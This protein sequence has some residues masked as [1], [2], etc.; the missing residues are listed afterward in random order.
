MI[1]R[2]R[3]TLRSLPLFILA[4]LTLAHGLETKP[5]HVG[6]EIREETLPLQL[7]QRVYEVMGLKEST[8][9][10][11]K[12]SYPASIPSS[13]SIRLERNAS[14]ISL[15]KS[16]RLLN[17]EKLIFKAESSDPAY[18]LVTVEAEGV[19]AQPHVRER[20]LVLFNIV[21][22]ELMLGIPHDAWWVGIAAFLCLIIALMIPRFLPLDQ[23]LKYDSSQ[24]AD[25]AKVS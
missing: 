15:G 14:G 1:R 20:D 25:I 8:W 3:R 21:C 24:E 10:E 4:S 6:K 22:D 16:R 18:V 9:Y 12:I 13:F 19:V 2:S 11:V 17:T 23:L 7:G 5:L